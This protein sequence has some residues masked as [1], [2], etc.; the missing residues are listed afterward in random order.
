MF[1]FVV[2]C[3]AFAVA[4]SAPSHLQAHAPYCSIPLS[5]SSRIDYPSHHVASHGSGAHVHVPGGHHH[6][7]HVH[8]SPAH[9]HVHVGNV[10]HIDHHI[11][12]LD[13]HVAHNAQAHGFYGW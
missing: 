7:A 1:K 12:H 11:G 9:G 5:Y 2:L 13:H 4:L 3:A 6:G 8:V 10:G